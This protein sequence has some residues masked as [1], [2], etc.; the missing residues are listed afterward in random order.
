MSI[1]EVGPAQSVYL[2]RWKVYEIEAG[3]RHLVGWDVDGFQGR[4][5]S[6]IAVWDPSEFKVITKSGRIY[7]LVGPS[8]GDSTA[9]YVWN[10]WK[11]I[12]GY[13]HYN[14]IDV[15]EEYE[16]EGLSKDDDTVL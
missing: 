13:D 4:V 14:Q 10:R 9:E 16:C 11:D 15:S 2:L 5:S 8:R 6:E 3:V 12:W 7:T 1:W